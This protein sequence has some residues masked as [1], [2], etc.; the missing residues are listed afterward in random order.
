[1]QHS[2]LNQLWYDFT[3]MQPQSTNVAVDGGPNGLSRDLGL[4]QSPTGLSRDSDLPTEQSLAEPNAS[5]TMRDEPDPDQLL[6][7]CAKHFLLLRSLRNSI[8]ACVSDAEATAS[9]SQQHGPSDAYSTSS[10]AYAATVGLLDAQQPKAAIFQQPATAAS[11]D[12]ARSQVSVSTDLARHQSSIN[13]RQAHPTSRPQPPFGFPAQFNQLHLAGPTSSVLPVLQAAPPAVPQNQAANS[14]DPIGIDVVQSQAATSQNAVPPLGND[15]GHQLSTYS[16]PD[17]AVNASEGSP[18][19]GLSRD[20]SEPASVRTAA[21]GSGD[22]RG[23]QGMHP[24]EEQPRVNSRRRASSAPSSSSQ[25]FINAPV[26]VAQLEATS[27]SRG[28]GQI[29]GSPQNGLSRDRAELEDNMERTS[30]AE[31]GV[32]ARQ[33]DNRACSN[34]VRGSG[35]TASTSAPEFGEEGT[36]AVAGPPGTFHATHQLYQTRSCI[37]CALCGMHGTHIK[38]TRLHLPCPRAPRNRWAKLASAELM[39]GVE[40]GIPTF[41]RAL[42]FTP[43]E[44]HFLSSCLLPFS[45]ACLSCRLHVR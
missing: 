40:F 1:M 13:T 19:N 6:S 31:T 2:K 7:D 21:P 10:V 23:R 22:T 39:N 42:S 17:H 36:D 30:S 28:R 9:D 37:F 3:S 25:A 12:E 8:R 44:A 5:T 16:W 33:K 32:A 41:Q 43:D 38:K 34:H 20:R 15:D 4:P 29:S 26:V 11:N 27:M 14:A 35:G 45:L 18:Q 24:A